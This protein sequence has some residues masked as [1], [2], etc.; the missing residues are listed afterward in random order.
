MTHEKLTVEKKQ[1]KVGNK[2]KIYKPSF[3]NY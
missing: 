2:F 3:E 1:I